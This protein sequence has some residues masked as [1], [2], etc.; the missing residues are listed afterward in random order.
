MQVIEEAVEAALVAGTPVAER[1][2]RLLDLRG[3]DAEGVGEALGVLRSPLGVLLLAALALRLE[4]VRDLLLRDPELP[5]ERRRERALALGVLPLVELAQRR[6]ELV[7]IDTELVG[8]I[9][10]GEPGRPADLVAP[11]APAAR[12]GLAAARRAPIA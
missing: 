10:S 1:L 3:L 2:E 7:G 5:G 11:S 8:E 12:D 4:R 6:V 9:G